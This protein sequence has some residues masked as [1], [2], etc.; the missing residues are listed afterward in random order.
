MLSIGLSDNTSAC[1]KHTSLGTYKPSS[2]VEIN[3]FI[4]REMQHY[5]QEILN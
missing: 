1:G 5:N 4:E 2:L 3:H